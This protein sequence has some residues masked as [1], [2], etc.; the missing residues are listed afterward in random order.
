MKKRITALLL[1][2]TLSVTSL[3]HVH[4]LT[5]RNPHQT[6]QQKLQN[7]QVLK[8]GTDSCYIK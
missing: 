2:L 3:L 4:L 7:P 5:N 1:L 6:K 8:T